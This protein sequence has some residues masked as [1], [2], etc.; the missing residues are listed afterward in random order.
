[1]KLGIASD[2]SASAFDG[3]PPPCAL[4]AE[5]TVIGACLIDGTM[6]RRAANSLTRRHFYSEA[7]GLI[8][9]AMVSLLTTGAAVDVVSTGAALKT[10]GR[11]PQCGGMAYLVS[12]MANVPSLKSLDTYVRAV[13]DT[14]RIREALGLVQRFQA[15]AYCGYDDAQGMLESLRVGAVACAD[16]GRRFAIA[17]NVTSLKEIIAT[18]RDTSTTGVTGIPT[19]I[20]PYDILTAGLHSKEVT[21]VGAR[22][23]MGKTALLLQWAETIASA[24]IGAGFI[25]LEMPAEDLALRLLASKSRLNSMSIRK[26]RLSPTDW[27]RLTAAANTIA[28]LPLWIQDA[29]AGVHMGQIREMVQSMLEKSRAKNTPLGVVFIDFLQHIARGPGEERRSEQEYLGNASRAIGN[30]AKELKI[31]FVVAVALNRNVEARSA[32]VRFPRMSDIR[33]CG[34]IES[35]ANNIFFL[36]RDAK[37]DEGGVESSDDSG[38]TY[39]ILAKQRNGP[40]DKTIFLRFIGSESRFVAE[41][42]ANDHIVDQ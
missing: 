31:P 33:A 42:G 34:N 38:R 35:D 12:A 9:E 17:D 21:I 19:G 23:G 10:A 27:S 3:K 37:V 13:Y 1:M 2:S 39:G 29:E 16:S 40:S 28:G 11:L 5:V 22:P 41:P 26:R 4:D 6:V 14:W 25:S 36:H 20:A 24:G 7:H 15:Q 18:I 30:M 32:S 8:W